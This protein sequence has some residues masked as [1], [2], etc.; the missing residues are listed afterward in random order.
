[1]RELQ[2]IGLSLEE[3]RIHLRDLLNK[4]R[5]GGVLATRHNEAHDDK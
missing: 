5:R 1:L 2:N 3:L 4:N